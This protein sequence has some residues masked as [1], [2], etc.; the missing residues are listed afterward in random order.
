MNIVRTKKSC[1]PSPV[2][3]V[4]CTVKSWPKSI[5]F[6]RERNKQQEETLPKDQD[7][8]EKVNLIK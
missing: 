2:R 5:E 8:V 3:T 4:S 1:N 7:R 6:V